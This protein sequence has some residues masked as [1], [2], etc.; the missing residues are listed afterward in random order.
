MAKVQFI[1]LS[2]YTVNLVIGRN[3]F[4]PIWLERSNRGGEDGGLFLT[5]LLSWYF[6]KFH[7]AL[8]W[9]HLTSCCKLT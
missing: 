6:D 3:G 4:Q 9:L 7:E 1:I 5:S 8:L 2:Q